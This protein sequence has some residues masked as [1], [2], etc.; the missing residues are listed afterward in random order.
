[1]NLTEQE[2][3]YISHKP[4]NSG[5]DFVTLKDV[6]IMKEHWPAKYSAYAKKNKLLSLRDEFYRRI[7]AEEVESI[8]KKVSFWAKLERC[9]FTSDENKLRMLFEKIKLIHERLNNEKDL[10]LRVKRKGNIKNYIDLEVNFF[11]PFFII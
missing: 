7:S 5:D 9:D 4:S 11:P 1:M 8:G 10:G 2:K 3:I 6:L